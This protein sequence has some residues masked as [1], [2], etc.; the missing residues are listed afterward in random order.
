MRVMFSVNTESETAY[1]HILNADLWSKLIIIDGVEYID[2]DLLLQ[3]I[4]STK[5]L[6]TQWLFMDHGNLVGI[7][8]VNATHLLEVVKKER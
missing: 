6:N 3:G 5:E 7:A 8:A 1:N 2:G 4:K